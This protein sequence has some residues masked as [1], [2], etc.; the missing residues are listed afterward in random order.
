MRQET[1]DEKQAQLGRRQS[2]WAGSAVSVEVVS[3]EVVSVETI[4]RDH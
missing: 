2:L 3:V 1:R 4:S